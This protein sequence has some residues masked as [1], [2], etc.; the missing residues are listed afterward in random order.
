MSKSTIMI[1]ED[2]VIL[3]ADLSDNLESM[4][5]NVMPIVRTGEDAL[6]RIEESKPDLVLMDIKI[7]GGMDGIETADA[8][9]KNDGPP[10]IFLTAFASDELIERAKLT[11]PFGYLVK[12]VDYKELKMTIEISLYKAALEKERDELLQKLQAANDEVKKLQSFIPICSNCKKIRD[13]KGYWEQVEHYMS[14]HYDATF[15]HSVCP[16]CIKVLYPV[17]NTAI[18]RPFP[19][20]L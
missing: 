5:Y 11:E 13:D 4:G 9:K 6:S 14:E 7:V 10:V 20:F 19:T 16:E 2:E 17:Q 1:V 8:I 15:T 3:A 12:P 18:F